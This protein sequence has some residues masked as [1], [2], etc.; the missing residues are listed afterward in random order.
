MTGA[1]RF[2]KLMESNP[3][4]AMKY[5]KEFQETAFWK[6]V[7]AFGQ[8]TLRD[9]LQQLYECD[10]EKIDRIRGRIDELGTFL[11]IPESAVD[12]LKDQMALDK[13]AAKVEAARQE[14]KVEGSGHGA[15]RTNV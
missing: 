1:E 4:S 7:H 2:E 11:A 10:K 6:Y 9:L 5:V 13:E 12:Q 8:Q 3:A 15:E 14:V